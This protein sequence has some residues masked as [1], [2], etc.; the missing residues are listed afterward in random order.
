VAGPV[1]SS[2]DRQSTEAAARRLEIEAPG[3][4]A[5]VR[6]AVARLGWRPLADGDARGALLEVEDLSSMDLDVPT[7]SRHRSLRVLKWG[8]KRLV[9][10]YLRYL[11][12]QVT[13]LGQA[14]AR[15]G[16]ALVEQ[17]ERLEGSNA[18]L[19]EAVT[20]LRS[21]VERLEEGPPR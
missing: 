15:L 7:L 12:Q 16:G 19:E 9:G 8:V 17:T 14:T 10:W 6:D 2:V 3:Y 5:K 20:E 11:G 18:R 13:A 21:R 4:L 1:P